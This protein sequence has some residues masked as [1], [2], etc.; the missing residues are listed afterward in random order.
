MVIIIKIL[1]ILIGAGLFIGLAG[2]IIC[3]ALDVMT[4]I[5]AYEAAAMFLLIALISFALYALLVI[6]AFILGCFGI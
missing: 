5:D 6:V 3:F 2:T 4:D 1:S